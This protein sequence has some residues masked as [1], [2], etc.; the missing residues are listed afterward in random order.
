MADERDDKWQVCEDK[1]IERGDNSEDNAW[2]IGINWTGENEPHYSKIEV[3]DWDKERG[4]DIA[5][6]VAAFLNEQEIE[7]GR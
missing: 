5:T 7:G 6:R 2:T 4:I 3:H 1:Y